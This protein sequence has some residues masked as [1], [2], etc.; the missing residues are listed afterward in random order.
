MFLTAPSL[1]SSNMVW[2]AVTR[3]LKLSLVAALLWSATTQRAHA[4]SGSDAPGRVTTL[5]AYTENDDWWPDTGTDKN[6]TN[7]FRGNGVGNSL[8]SFMP[9]FRFSL[10][11][12]TG[13]DTFLT[14][15]GFVFD[16]V[17][18]FGRPESRSAF[19]TR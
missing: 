18:V 15:S 2:P 7:T 19:V 8:N 11:R 6:Y 12:G 10:D 5:V 16:F 14:G 3:L 4:Q 1:A 13:P 17:S 9:Y